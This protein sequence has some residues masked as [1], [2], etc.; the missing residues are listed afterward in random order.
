MCHGR[1]ARE[2]ASKNRWNPAFGSASRLCFAPVSPVGEELVGLGRPRLAAG[3]ADAYHRC[4]S[5]SRCARCVP[6]RS[7]RSLQSSS[8]AFDGHCI[9]SVSAPVHYAHTGRNRA[10]LCVVWAGAHGAGALQ[11]RANTGTRLSCP[12]SPS[13]PPAAG[14]T[15]LRKLRRQLSPFASGSGHTSSTV[16][17][18]RLHPNDRDD[19]VA[20]E[21]DPRVLNLTIGT[22]H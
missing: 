6:D 17:R 10:H 1:G 9:N 5:S 21:S 4:I 13:L 20:L 19:G 7:L 15:G 8:A 16:E 3:D 12:P 18:P 14:S 22:T 2:V 11:L